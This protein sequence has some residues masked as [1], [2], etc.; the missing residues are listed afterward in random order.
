MVKHHNNTAEIILNPLQHSKI[1]RLNGYS[2]H[3]IV[4][5]FLLAFEI[6]WKIANLNSTREYTSTD[7]S[8]KKITCFMLEKITNVNKP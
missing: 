8:E 3:L 4:S 7:W 5:N 6:A 2:T 1:A